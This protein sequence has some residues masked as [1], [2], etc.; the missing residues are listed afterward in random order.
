MPNHTFDRIIRDI[1]DTAYA[2]CVTSQVGRFAGLEPPLN[3]QNQSDP[4]GDY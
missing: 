1:R 4:A 3:L 2:N